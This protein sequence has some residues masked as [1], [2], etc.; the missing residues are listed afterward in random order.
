M[1]TMRRV[2]EGRAVCEMVEILD[3]DGNALGKE[4]YPIQPAGDSYTLENLDTRTVRYSSA[5]SGVSAETGIRI[6]DESVAPHY[7]AIKVRSR[8]NQGDNKLYV[9]MHSAK[10]GNAPEKGEVFALEVYYHIDY[11][12]PN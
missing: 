4:T 6:L 7:I 3:A 2:Y 1:F 8:E 5:T 11:T 12:A 9:S 10:N